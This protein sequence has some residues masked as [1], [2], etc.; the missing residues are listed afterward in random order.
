MAVLVQ[1]LDLDLQDLDLDLPEIPFFPKKEKVVI[2]ITGKIAFVSSR[3]GSSN[4]YTM[5][6][7]GSNI[8]RLTKMKLGASY[9]SWS[10]DGEKIAFSSGINLPGVGIHIYAVSVRGGKP[11]KL[12]KSPNT[13]NEYP[14]WSPDG[15]MIAFAS[16][17]LKKNDIGQIDQYNIYVMN[18]DGSNVSKL[19][20]NGGSYPTW[21]P[22]GENIA[23]SSYQDSEYG[24]IYIMNKNGSNQIKITETGYLEIK[25]PSGIL[26]KGTLDSPINPCWSPDGK[27]I[28]FNAWFGQ[29]QIF[30]INADGSNLVMLT[31]TIDAKNIEPC[32][33]P[34]GKMIAFFSNRDD[35][36]DIY[37]M[38]TDGSNVTQ[39]TKHPEHD[40]C[41]T[42]SPS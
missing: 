12:T 18:A 27:K 33:S 26:I 38:N 41:P 14:A 34:D 3:D 32:W 5:D 1:Y 6:T 7:N 15:K 16:A 35:S 29:R 8:T 30:V 20:K 42:W 4:I 10:P 22:D 11:I 40:M 23:F 31:D 9:P 21:S 17:T 25:S 39:L 24:N 13:V 28:A 2:S 19:T 36:Y 37:V